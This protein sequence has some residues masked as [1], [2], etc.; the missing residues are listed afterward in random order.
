MELA[1]DAL[2]AQSEYY[3]IRCVIILFLIVS[4][5]IISYSKKIDKD[6]SVY[7]VVLC[8]FLIVYLISSVVPFAKDALQK[9]IVVET[10]V[11]SNQRSQG[12]HGRATG[13]SYPDLDTG[14]KVLSL[15][16]PPGRE[17]IF[18]KGT[19]E[20]LAYYLPNAKVLLHIEII[21]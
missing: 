6:L 10:G 20:V 19:H 3:L 4:S 21:S 5:F 16:T 17:S 11:Y 18:I 9:N 12:R 8:I 15:K 7:G 2:R 14:D 13:I 1:L